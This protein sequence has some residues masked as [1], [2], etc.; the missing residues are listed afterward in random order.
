MKVTKEFSLLNK[1]KNF[2]ERF[3]KFENISHKENH[4]IEIEDGPIYKSTTEPVYKGSRVE[5]IEDARKEYK[6]TL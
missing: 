5:S 1:Q 6:K 4:F 2:V 3:K